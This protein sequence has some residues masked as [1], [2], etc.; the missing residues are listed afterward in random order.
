M[1]V[2]ALILGPLLVGLLL[3]LRGLR[4]RAALLLVAAALVSTTLAYVEVIAQPATVVY[5]S[6]FQI[7]ATA[8]LFLGF[9]DPIFL[10]ISVYVWNRVAGTPALARGMARFTALALVF[11]AAA[12]AVLL[13]NH[14][15]VGWLA[16]EVTTLSAALLIA[17]PA[18]AAARLASFRYL[19][20]SSVGLG[21]VL[22]GFVCLGRGLDAGGVA[23]S[24]FLDRLEAA[25]SA[26][27]NGWGTLGLALVLL[28]L[29]TK[30]GLAPM[31]SWLPEAYDE[32]PPAV[33][34]LL[35][36]VQFNAALVVLLRVVHLFRPTHSELITSQL[37]AM[38]LVSMSI[39][40]FSIIATRNVTRLI[41]YA[42][43]N[44]AGV[45][46]IGIGI[47]RTAAYGLLLYVIS[48]AF[49]KA[50]LFLT[51]GKIKAYYGTKDT[52]QIAG[53]LKDL[54][55]S[56]LFLMVGTF[57]LL[58]FPPFGSFFGELLVLSALIGSGHLFVFATFC[59]LITMTFI[60]TG[61]TI[62]PMIWGEPKQ[63]RTWPRQRFI[64]AAPKL[65]FLVALLVLGVYIPPV[66]NDLLLAVA[67][68]MGTS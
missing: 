13:A 44:H 23:P 7:D 50:I 64:S 16:L 24:L 65:A 37:L 54:P 22:L 30:L 33:T 32:A 63:R 56:G 61:K 53:L 42:S 48:N 47:G 20:F 46:A 12:H 27:A 5:T 15:L 9:M 35:G 2:L 59:L 55:Y 45:I 67:A 11:F 36:A 29:G 43:I 41:A 8:R 60:A 51:V 6:Y 4:R 26:A 57:A 68:S 31:Y 40:T 39:S 18:T 62:F 10:G 25:A 66:V 49:V 28:G 34:A 21:L 17:R 38:G 52:G 58:G 14:L 3:V 19:L 1:I